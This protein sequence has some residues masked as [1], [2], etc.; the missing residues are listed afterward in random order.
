MKK[1]LGF[2]IVS[3][4]F[5]AFY[6]LLQYF[7]SASD[8]VRIAIFSVCGTLL[9]AIFCQFLI[10]DR[11]IAARHHT[12]KKN[13]YMP[14]I[15]LCVE[16]MEAQKKGEEIPF[17]ELMEQ[18][19]NYK[20]ELLVWGSVEVIVAMNNYEEVADEVDVSVDKLLLSVENVFRAMRKDL[21]HSDASLEKGALIGIFLHLEARRAIISAFKNMT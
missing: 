2:V 14:F 5:L 15:N 11:E 4:V 3:L 13:A 12:E 8:N 9:G 17:D 18:G 19:F 10:N 1:V 20:K 7:L 16:V 6:F 21:G